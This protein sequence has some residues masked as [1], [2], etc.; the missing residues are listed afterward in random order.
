MNDV[1]ENERRKYLANALD[2]LSTAC[3]TVGGIAPLAALVYG[4]GTFGLP[5]GF[6][7]IA[8]GS[9]LLAAISL[10]WIGREVLGG[11]RP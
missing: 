7:W 8:T 1:V 10:H 2:R 3:A 6:F 11:L 4:N 5:V 9:W